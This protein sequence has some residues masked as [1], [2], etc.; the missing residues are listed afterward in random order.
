MPPGNR[1]ACCADTLKI[2]THTHSYECGVFDKFNNRKCPYCPLCCT[3]AHGHMLITTVQ[4]L[5]S[6]RF[7][8]IAAAVSSDMFR[9]ISSKDNA[10][11]RCLMIDTVKLVSD[12]KCQL[13]SYVKNVNL[14]FLARAQFACRSRRALKFVAI[15]NWFSKFAKYNSN[16]TSSSSSQ[17]LINNNSKQANIGFCYNEKAIFRIYKE[18]K[19]KTLKTQ[20][21]QGIVSVLL[22]LPLLATRFAAGHCRCCCCCCYCQYVAM[23]GHV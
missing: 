3:H 2:S 11:A 12:S 15:K 22:L 17:M 7:W 13:F 1:Y 8:L 5:R 10:A 14:P 6:S 16:K 4:W 18:K 23:L 9:R 19:K 21:S 20:S